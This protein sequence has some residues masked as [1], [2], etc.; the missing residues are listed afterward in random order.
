MYGDKMKYIIFDN[1][2]AIIFNPVI[3]HSNV[4]VGFRNGKATSAGFV[5]LVPAEVG[6]YNYVNVT[7]HGESVSLGLK[8]G[9]D[10]DEEIIQRMINEK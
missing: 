1:R 4:S 8:S 7:V 5:T 3:V 6:N 2:T 9:G 10:K